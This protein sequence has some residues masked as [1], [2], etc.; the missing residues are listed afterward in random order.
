MI[1]ESIRRNISDMLFLLGDERRKLPFILATFLVVSLLDLVGV[2]LVGSYIALF[3]QPIGSGNLSFLQPIFSR[4]GNLGE[5][6]DAAMVFLGLILV[7][8]F[9]LKAIVGLFVQRIIF[10][11]CFKRMAYLRTSAI[12]A[13]QRMPY[14]NFLQRNSSEYVQ[15]VINY[16]GQYTGSLRYTLTLISDGTVAIVLFILLSWVSGFALALVIAIGVV[17]IV[18]YDKVFRYKI[19]RAGRT[20][21]IGNELTIRGIQEGAAGF[22]EIRILGQES[23]FLDQVRRG[24]WL[25]ANSNNLI[26]LIQAIPRYMVEVAIISFVVSVVA[27][28]V[29]QGQSIES[30]YPVI[31]MLAVALLRL[32]PITNL[33]MTA[34]SSL[35]S[36]RPG[37]KLLRKEFDYLGSMPTHENFDLTTNGSPFESLELKNVSFTYDNSPFP[38]LHNITMSIVAGES[39]GLVGSSGSGKTT[40]VDV[41]LGLLVNTS[42]ELFYNRNPLSEGLPSWRRNVAYLPQ[43]VFMIDDSFRNNISFGAANSDLDNERLEKALMQSQLSDLVSE[44]PD[45]IDTQLGEQGIR[46]SGGQR[47]R[48]ALARAFYHQREVLVLDEATSALDTDTEREIVQEMQR[49]KGN[50]TMIVIA[51]RLSTLQH[52]D[53]IYKLKRGEIVE[54]GSYRDM[55]S[56]QE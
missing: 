49:L 5:D 50:V 55:I 27:I 15:T 13:I 2:G 38:A 42:G 37:I 31:G 52:C 43:E 41:I 56:N 28:M 20:L 1:I 14:S 19:S 30:T 3:T 10:R 7:A 40:L 21:N 11:F 24:S 54:V 53:R 47:Q 29:L 25:V 48:V 35:R 44:L 32:A 12:E 18:G 51:H 8:V 34:I 26:L 9:V 36:N 6:R 4:F 46:L 45:G 23:Y 17:M 33:I 39:V 22:K 16:V